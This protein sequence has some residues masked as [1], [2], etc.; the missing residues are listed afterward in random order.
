MAGMMEERAQVVGVQGRYALVRA[1][2]PAGG[3]G[4]CAMR[5][6]CGVSALGKLL[7]RPV[8]TWKVANTVAAEVGDAVMVGVPDATLLTAAFL[9]YL[10]PLLSLLAGAAAAASI[11]TSD[12]MV[13]LGALLGLAGGIVLAHWQSGRLTARLT[14]S[15]TRRTSR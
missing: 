11:S 4:T 8:R 1:A 7:H 13:A 6:G 14:P 15:I 10:V 2:S 5:A 9:A 12:A 3:C